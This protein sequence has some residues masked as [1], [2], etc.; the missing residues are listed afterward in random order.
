MNKIFIYGIALTACMA[1]LAYGL[2]LWWC[3]SNDF[4]KYAKEMEYCR[5]SHG[6][7]YFGLTNSAIVCHN[8][9][10]KMMEDEYGGVIHFPK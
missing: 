2:S 7:D 1:L 3:D 8:T 6:M 9:T 5:E 10:H 4:C